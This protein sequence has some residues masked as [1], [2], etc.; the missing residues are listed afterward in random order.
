MEEEIEDNNLDWLDDFEKEDRISTVDTTNF[1][2]ADTNEI[3]IVEAETRK[4]INAIELR[5][6]EIGD[7]ETNLLINKA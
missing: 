6:E 2:V 4:N 7:E 5:R 1:D 3:G